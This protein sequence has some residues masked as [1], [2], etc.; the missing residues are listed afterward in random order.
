MPSD[1]ITPSFLGA[2]ESNFD[3][4]IKKWKEFEAFR[5]STVLIVRKLLQ[6]LAFTGPQKDGNLIAWVLNEHPNAVQIKDCS[7]NAW[8]GLLSDSETEASLAIIT[9]RCLVSANPAIATCGG[10]LLE[11]FS[12]LRTAIS[13]DRRRIARKI[14]NFP[15]ATGDRR[16]LQN[17]P[18]NAL[19]H[20]DGGQAPHDQTLNFFS[21]DKTAKVEDTT[22]KAVVRS[23]DGQKAL[24]LNQ[25]PSDV[26][27][28]L[29]LVKVASGIEY[30]AGLVKSF[31][32]G[33]IAYQEETSSRDLVGVVQVCII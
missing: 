26:I 11:S 17:L 13:P 29:Q 19:N 4:F 25:W 6:S 33:R 8:V 15:W 31:G 5:L 23:S 22:L 21:R 20:R 2:F 32:G 16:S 14:L 12:A 24:H 7:H 27:T 28:G 9:D 3:G 30:T 1:G 18:E 10:P